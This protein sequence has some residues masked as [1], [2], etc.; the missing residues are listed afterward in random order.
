[1]AVRLRLRRMGR[2][3]RPFYRIVAADQRAPR[4]GRFIEVVGQYD[5]LQKPQ[6]VEIKEERIYYW[7]A[8]GAQVTNTVRSL[9][10]SKGIWM[11]LD[12]KARG[13]TDEQI[14]T[15]MQSWQENRIARGK[16]RESAEIQAQKKKEKTKKKEEQEKEESAETEVKE[17]KEA[18]TEEKTIAS[19]DVQEAKAEEVQVE[20]EVEEIQ[21]EKD[22]GETEKLNEQPVEAAEG[23]DQATADEPLQED[24]KPELKEQQEAADSADKKE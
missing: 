14:A 18:T 10:R 12:L 17:V 21:L 11:R 13:L 16:R 22:A 3:K 23:S 15:E 4:D 1:L 19:E 2:K 9:L 24:E 8:N 20:Q 5:P 7:L 6:I